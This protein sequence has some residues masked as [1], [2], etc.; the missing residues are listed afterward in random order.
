VRL[1]DFDQHLLADLERQRP[2]LDLL[3][4]AAVDQLEGLDRQRVAA[5]EVEALAGFLLD[6]GEAAV[7]VRSSATGTRAYISS[8]AAAINTRFGSAPPGLPKAWA[9]QRNIKPYWA[10][11]RS[12]S[13]A[14]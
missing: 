7:L 13:L 8:I 11:P 14:A 12:R 9:R 2:L 3:A 10:L 5:L 1:V 4:A 6:L